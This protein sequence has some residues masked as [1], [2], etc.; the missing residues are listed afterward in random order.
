MVRHG[1]SVINFLIFSNKHR[2]SVDE[3][4][5]H[6]Y[7]GCSSLGRQAGRMLEYSQWGTKN[8][9]IHGILSKLK[10]LQTEVGEKANFSVPFDPKLSFSK[11]EG[12]NKQYSENATKTTKTTYVV[13]VYF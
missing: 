4:G 8:M 13:I 7:I 1:S 9:Y 3:K 2:I 11:S 10:E 5:I 6:E 12:E